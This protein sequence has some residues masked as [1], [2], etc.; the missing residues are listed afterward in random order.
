MKKKRL[1]QTYLTIVVAAAL[2]AG[3]GLA[4]KPSLITP[5][6]AACSGGG[7]AG[8]PGGKHGNFAEHHG[9]LKALWQHVLAHWQAKHQ[10]SD[11][12]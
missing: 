5:A 9:W 7:V 4:G 6:Q 10:K 2:V 3:V 12:G 11:A 1:K 8:N